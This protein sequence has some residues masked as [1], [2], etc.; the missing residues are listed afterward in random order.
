M[1]LSGDGG[2]LLY[3]VEGPSTSKVMQG[4]KYQQFNRR[5]HLVIRFCTTPT[6]KTC[7]IPYP[8]QEF[9]I[10][11][12]R[13]SKPHP[14]LCSHGRVLQHEII[15][16]IHPPPLA[17]F[18]F[19]DLQFRIRRIFASINTSWRPGFFKNSALCYQ[20]KGTHRRRVLNLGPSTSSRATIRERQLDAVDI[21]QHLNHHQ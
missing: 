5:R 1:H 11:G 4:S 20:Q 7:I 12:I 14:K 10:I 8:L 16:Y 3:V 17:L 13:Y 18:W 21:F 2:L 9:Q 6:T 19:H 15:I